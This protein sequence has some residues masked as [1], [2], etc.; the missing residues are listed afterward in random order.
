MDLSYSN[1]VGV[2]IDQIR[3]AQ[4]FFTNN[5]GL[6]NH[7]VNPFARPNLTN[8]PVQ[9]RNMYPEDSNRVD[10]I[11]LSTGCCGQPGQTFVIGRKSEDVPIENANP[12][13]KEL[14]SVPHKNRQTGTTAR[15]E[16]NQTEN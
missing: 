9:H 3:F 16:F 12:F 4:Q 6:N 13:W 1:D 7:S 8:Q 11:I 5:R 15:I 10:E 14:Q 2:Q